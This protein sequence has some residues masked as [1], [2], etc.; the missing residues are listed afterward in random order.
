[1]RKFGKILKR[2]S[3][4]LLAIIISVG[5]IA[6]LCAVS[7]AESHPKAVNQGKSAQEI[8]TENLEQFS[9]RTGYDYHEAGEGDYAPGELIVEFSSSSEYA[10]DSL[11]SVEK[12]F[13]ITLKKFISS[14]ELTAEEGASADSLNSGSNIIS[15]YLMETTEE[16][17]IS[18]CDELNQRSDVFNAQPNFR[19]EICEEPEEVNLFNESQAAAF[20]EP[21]AFGTTDYSDNLKWWFDYCNVSTAWS[22]YADSKTGYGLGKGIKVAVIDTGCNTAHEDIVDNLWDDGKGHCGYYAYGGTFHTGSYISKNDSTNDKNS[23]G[24]HCC[25]TI[26][27]SGKNTVGGIGTAP[28]CSLI[29]LKADRDTG[30]GSFFDSEL[31][32]S[33]EKA[34][35][36]GAD[37][38]SMS[39]GGYNFSY[40]TYRTYQKV[41][42][43]CLILC[44]AGNDAM[45][46]TEKLHFPSAASCVMGI[47]ALGDSSSRT[48]L[49]TF[50]NYD[51]TG[52][53]YKIA[54]PG[55]G[56]Y[57]LDYSANN[58]YCKMNGTSMATP[59]AAGMVAS[60]MSY[61][62]Y[63]KG[64]DWT[65]AQYQYKIENI[66]SSNTYNSLNC[67]AYSRYYHK[68]AYDKGSQF[69]V[70]NLQSL[71]SNIASTSSN[72][73]SNTNAVK[74]ENSTIQSG[75][76][77][78]TGLTAAELDSYALQRVSLMYWSSDSTRKNIT[79]YSEL[80]KLTGLN[81][82]DLSGSSKF[83]SS[84][85]ADVIS[86]CPATL[87]YLDL[88]TSN[89]LGN[90][91]CLARSKF[92]CLHYLNIASN[93][94]TSLGA[95]TK[96]TSLK[97]LYANSNSIVDI[98]PLSGMTHLE[99]IELQNNLIQDPNPAF[100]SDLC[101]YIDLSNNKLSDHTQLL[102]FKGAYHNKSLNSTTITLKFDNNN[103]TGLSSSYASTIRQ[104]INDQNTIDG[105]NKLTSLT[106]S[107]SNQTS[108][109]SS[110]AMTSFSISNKTVSREALCS[111]NLNSSAITGFTPYPSNANK[112]N[113]LKWSCSEPGYFGADGTVLVNPEQI[114]SCR[115]LT[116]SASAP[117]ASGIT[118]V[119]TIKLTITAPEIINSYLSERVIKTGNKAGILVA[120]NQYTPRVYLRF[121][122]SGSDP[123]TVYGTMPDET[124][125]N[126]K[127][128][129]NFFY[130]PDSVTGTAGT[131][132]CYVYAADSNNNYVTAGNTDITG[133]T[134]YP[135][136]SLGTLYVKDSVENSTDVLNITCDSKLNRYGQPLIYTTNSGTSSTSPAKPTGTYSHT[137]KAA[138][139]KLIGDGAWYPTSGAGY[140]GKSYSGYPNVQTG[141]AAFSV[142]N[143]ENSAVSSVEAKTTTQNPEV[144]AVEFRNP[145]TYGTDGYAEYL[146][147]TNTAATTLKA[148]KV[149][150]QE[151]V[152]SEL[153]NIF[154]SFNN[155]P[156]NYA[157]YN[158]SYSYKLW[159]IKVPLVSSKPQAVTFTAADPL[160]DGSVSM[161]PA[162]GIKFSGAQYFYPGEK[163]YKYCS[164]YITFLPTD[165]EG[166]SLANCLKTVTYTSSDNDYFT[167]SGSRLSWNAQKVLSK[168]EE[169]TS[170]NLS[171][172]ITATLQIIGASDNFYVYA[173]RPTV[174][175]LSYDRTTSLL[176]PGGT[177][178]F[179]VKTYGADTIY[180][181][182]TSDSN[183][184]PL[185]TLSKDTYDSYVEQADSKGNIYTV[186]SFERTFPEDEEMTM[187]TYV[188]SSYDYS[189]TLTANSN[190]YSFTS[191]KSVFPGDYSAWNE[192]LS[193]INDELLEKLETDYGE[194]Q[195]SYESYLEAVDNTISS[196]PE[197]LPYSSQSRIDSAT[198]QLEADIDLLV[199]LNDYNDALEDFELL[200]DNG[201]EMFIT[202]DFYEAI[203]TQ[204]NDNNYKE[205]SKLINA[206]I[207][208]T[209]NL[210]NLYSQLTAYAEQ[211]KTSVP[212][213]DSDEIPLD[214]TEETFT[215]LKQ[216]KDLIAQKVSEGVYY[217]ADEMNTDFEALRSAFSQL[218]KHQYSLRK[219]LPS[220]KTNG[221]EYLICIECGQLFE[222]SAENDTL[223]PVGKFDSVEEA[224]AVSLVPAPAFNIFSSDGYEYNQHAGSLRVSESEEFTD[225]KATTQGLRFTASVQIPDGISFRIGADEDLPQIIDVGYVYSQTKLINDD[226]DNLVLNADNVYSISVKSKNTGAFDGS[227]WS[228]LTYHSEEKTLTYNLVINV[229]A[230][231]WAEDYCARAY[232]TYSYKGFS[233]TVYDSAYSSRSVEFIAN[234]V[235]NSPT[236]SEQAKEYCRAKILSNL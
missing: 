23:H 140:F 42:S 3:T 199:G 89:Q 118:T 180:I 51:T 212:E 12:Q 181:R 110:V 155:T 221:Y 72:P 77:N 53:F 132:T 127:A 94:M 201:Y 32:T 50:S 43:S 39:L 210:G 156:G 230:C 86:K 191:V 105:E 67:G 236:E 57:S 173:Y 161:T 205:L 227:N 160:G 144:K 18:L 149:E 27:M 208:R 217:S 111:G 150:T 10:S 84:T 85:I 24:S 164:D 70:F 183:T 178:H 9:E 131:Y 147:K 233:Y 216:A 197:N 154:T 93:N 119:K 38:V 120:T 200:I 134:T 207:E 172:K 16:D 22:N 90:L 33:L 108:A 63:V 13:P 75:I 175:S 60:Y 6:S 65:P 46:T 133:R 229:K 34:A 234:E 91:T 83:T 30:T 170:A 106:F 159:S 152:C 139:K 215:A 73:F 231:N 211:I 125:A 143:S 78:A 209:N 135:Y 122:K 58:K 4:L 31:K 104:K 192:Q 214:Y 121:T 184:T 87:L 153:N 76:V 21:P 232:V 107:Y 146:V 190:T 157:V 74:F 79:D 213:I 128:K 7:Y 61:I 195:S 171:T 142:S 163:N 162:T 28:E 225:F 188:R 29:V 40:S 52:N 189:D 35:E 220:D 138:H 113:Y 204:A 81:Y 186:W 80:S 64:W 185:M 19:Y 41:S 198:E 88:S 224:E 96:F 8:E 112:Y 36:F 228:G 100:A 92:P 136:K 25:G 115:T 158:S 62:K 14:E 117:E 167:L 99:R 218:H 223:K 69:K 26:A 5:S 151:D 48:K 71:F 235:I 37:I 2:I 97:E 102:N 95:I 176:V 55:T 137:A 109:T 168:L 103:L 101:N 169:G 196:L 182:D 20:T 98:S 194:D 206:H 59:A 226:T 45:D 116:L 219:Q 54:A 47:M 177:V 68:I 114:T 166:K 148:Y 145:N 126:G 187:R 17:I 1:M 15:S 141:E 123:V 165:S 44:A 11:L 56:I 222:A 82:L 130:V 179:T 193:R 129:I 49:A 174:S 66:L 203:Q 202:Q 124:V